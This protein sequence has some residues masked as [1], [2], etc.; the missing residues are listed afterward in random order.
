MSGGRS[1]W[2]LWQITVAHAGVSFVPVVLKSS[3]HATHAATSHVYARIPSSRHTHA[4]A[5][6]HTHTQEY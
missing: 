6:T 4:H 5:D 2:R 1:L 3:R